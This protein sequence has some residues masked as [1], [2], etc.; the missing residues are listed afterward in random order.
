MRARPSAL[1]VSESSGVGGRA[2]GAADDV[3]QPAA[4]QRLAAGEAHLAD[5]EVLDRDADQPDDLVV[6]EH[7]V[8]G[9]PV[10]A[11]GGHAVG[12]AQVA[13]VGQRDAQV[14][15]HPAVPVGERAP[16]VTPQS[17]RVRHPARPRT[18]TAR[19][20]SRVRACGSC[21]AAAGCCSRSW[22]RCWRARVVA[23][24]VAVPPARG[25]QGRNAIVERNEGRAPRPSP[26]S[27]RPGRPGAAER[28][29]APWSPRPGRTPSRTP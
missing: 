28:R 26:T 11:L 29:V 10:E 7:L 6:G 14:G 17:R 5:A 24:R 3:D 8:V 12:A 22:W 23:R 20:P 18:P 2:R 19:I 25:P 4:H 9:Q 27:W 13:A 16:V 15:G 1:V 21:S